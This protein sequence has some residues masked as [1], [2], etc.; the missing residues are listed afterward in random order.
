MLFDEIVVFRLFM[1]FV[2]LFIV[3]EYVVMVSEMLESFGG[4]GYVEDMGLL[5]ILWDGQVLFI[6]EGIINVL[7][8]D[9]LCAIDKN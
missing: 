1:L 3:K 8:L 6:W 7:S 4:V 9:V 5:V 2:K